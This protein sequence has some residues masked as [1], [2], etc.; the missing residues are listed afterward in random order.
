MSRTS[1]TNAKAE[2]YGLVDD[3]TGVTVAYDH[4]PVLSGGINGPVALC[5]FTAG[6]DAD[7]WQIGVRL[8]VSAAVDAKDAQDTLDLLM[9]RVDV[10]TNTG[11]YGPAVWQVDYPTEESPFFTAT[12]IYNVGRQ[13]Y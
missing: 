6:M 3:I 1:L 12:C 7:F 5:V 9:P 11:G 8:L 10:A 4:Q 13:D 2:L